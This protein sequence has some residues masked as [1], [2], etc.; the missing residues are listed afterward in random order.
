MTP[1]FVL[2]AHLSYTPFFVHDQIALYTKTNKNSI[3]LPPRFSKEA[4]KDRQANRGADPAALRGSLPLPG[5]FTKAIPEGSA[6][7]SRIRGQPCERSIGRS[8]GL[9]LPPLDRATGPDL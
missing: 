9:S 3:G 1:S 5:P 8:H 7:Y 6:P 2:G 4:Q